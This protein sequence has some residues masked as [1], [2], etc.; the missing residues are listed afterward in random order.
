MHTLFC[1]HTAICLNHLEGAVL[2]SCD[3]LQDLNGQESVVIDACRPTIREWTGGEPRRFLPQ[4]AGR[5]SHLRI[6]VVHVGRRSAKPASSSAGRRQRHRRGFLLVCQPRVCRWSELGW[7]AGER[8]LRLGC[9]HSCSVSHSASFPS[10]LLASFPHRAC[11][12][13][14]QV[15]N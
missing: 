2:T 7:G 4:S 10:K 1:M 3:K 9:R 5:H 13:L 11:L 6:A 8:I 15:H 12:K 14:W